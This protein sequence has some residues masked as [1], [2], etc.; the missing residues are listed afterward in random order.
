MQP[1]PSLLS[2]TAHPNISIIITT[3]NY[4]LTH[5][6][7]HTLSL[8]FFSFSLSLSIYIYLSLSLYIYIYLSLS[9]LYTTQSMLTCVHNSD[10]SPLIAALKVIETSLAYLGQLV[11]AERGLLEKLRMEKM[12]G[13]ALR[14][15]SDNID[16]SSTSFLLTRGP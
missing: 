16:D 14:R 1:P 4:Y 12:R 9:R 2:R 10:K 3:T 6:H 15:T 11:A 7:T 8:S 5:T 13:V